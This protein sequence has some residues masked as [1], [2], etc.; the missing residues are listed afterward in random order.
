MSARRTYSLAALLAL[1][2]LTACEGDPG[3]PG[4]SNLPDDLY[5]PTVEIILPIASRPIY[6]QTVVETTVADDDS[7]AR[8][9]FIVDGAA[10]TGDFVL[11]KPPSLYTWDTG[12]LALGRHTLQLLAWDRRGKVGESALLYLD[13]RDR[14]D[15]LRDTLRFFAD[16]A[17]AVH[18]DWKLP[19]DSLGSFAGLAVRFT[20]DRPCKVVAVGVK[21]RRKANWLGTQLDLDLMSEANGRPDTLTDATQIT[22]RLPPEGSPEYNDWVVKRRNGVS[23]SGEFFAVVRLKEDA[24]RD[25]LAVQTDNGG[26]ANGHGLMLTNDGMWH[27]I[28]AARGRRPNPLIYVVVLYQ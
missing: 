20:P 14:P 24:G 25:T 28:T 23:F 26:W 7:V 21:L 8:M 15:D 10:A 2:F 5:P 9:E 19:T 22:L 6:D 17:R 18:T 13:R 4:T 12:G 27:S 11:L 16:S 3:R 1:P